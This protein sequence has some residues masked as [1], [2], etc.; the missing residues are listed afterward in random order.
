M[1]ISFLISWWLADWQPFCIS[2]WDVRG[3]I[4]NINKAI[5]VKIQTP[6]HISPCNFMSVGT[7]FFAYCNYKPCFIH[8]TQNFEVP[9]PLVFCN[10]P[11]G[12]I[13]IKFPLS[14]S[15]LVQHR[16]GNVLLYGKIIS[17]FF[18]NKV[19]IRVPVAYFCL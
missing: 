17:I 10:C 16:T 5:H 6:S 2:K 15:A 7:Q 1:S 12:A 9:G 13:H 4:S 8:A 11:H 3:C 18:D 14:L 19:K